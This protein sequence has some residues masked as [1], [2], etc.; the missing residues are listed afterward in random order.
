M[1]KSIFKKGTSAFLAVLMCLSTF[2]GIGSTT[3]F[4][5]EST[6]AEVV[7]MSFPREGDD[8]FGGDWGHGEL[9]YMNGW[10]AAE[11]KKITVYTVGSW[12]G[13]ACYC[14]EP[15][16]P[17]AIGD[18]MTKRD[19]TYWD[20][21]PSTY[22]KTISADEIKLFIGRIFQY[23][24][25]GTVDI[26]WR[27]QNS[28]DADK[29]AH[30]MHPEWKM[31]GDREYYGVRVDTTNYAYMLRFTPRQGDYNSYCH[32]YK[33]E[34]LDKHLE[35]AERGIRFIDPHYN[36]RFVI[37]D[38]DTIRIQME[39]NKYADYTCRYIDDYHVE[40]GSQ[41]YHICQFAELME[42][43]GNSVTPL[44]SSL[45]EQCFS[46]LPSTG[47]LIV[48]AKGK[49]GYAPCYD[50]SMRSEAE[51]REFAN[52]RNIKMGVTKAQEQAMLGGSMFGW[53]ISTRALSRNM[54]AV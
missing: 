32:C 10:S 42:Q 13:N 47:E 27:S 31:G 22:N 17:L 19:E 14:I 5:A 1:K 50:F 49:S 4:A 3:A 20:N 41:L 48:I 45:P 21:Y 26:D 46:T 44:R 11:T 18:V 37:P 38:G 12:S 16:T 2:L 23:G 7:M 29:M 25:T 34:W 8:N 24:Y 54:Q 51:N 43:N 6:T 39:D 30:I 28:A 9:R 15:G 36:E 53:D 33:K 40:V 52:D 35:N